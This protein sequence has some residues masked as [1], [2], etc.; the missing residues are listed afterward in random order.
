MKARVIFFFKFL[1]AIALILLL[2]QYDIINLRDIEILFASPLVW[3]AASLLV[4]LALF[5]G[6][7]RWKILLLGVGVKETYWQLL[8]IYC[9]SAFMGMFLPGALGQDAVRTIHLIHMTPRGK[10]AVAI[11]VLVD[12]VMGLFGFLS[13]GIVII[14]IERETML[15]SVVTTALATS[16]VLIFFGMLLAGIVLIAPP[17]S[18]SP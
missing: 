10:T 11:S 9:I 15:S 16:V 3:L 7:M 8:Q 6:V 12:R 18:L 13:V 2:F 5:V 17:E 4:V 1:L 14:W